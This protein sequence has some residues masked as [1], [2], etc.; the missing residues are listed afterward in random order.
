MT[1]TMR[2]PAHECGSALLLAIFLA[3]VLAATIGMLVSQSVTCHRA[4]QSYLDR[5]LAYRSAESGLQYFVHQAS[6]DTGYFSDLGIDLPVVAMGDAAFALE[7]VVETS[8]S[9]WEIIVAGSANGATFRL[10]AALGYRLIEIPRGLT[11]VGT[12]SRTTVT[13]TLSNGSIVGSFDPED[14]PFDPASPGANGHVDINGGINMSGSS[15][16]YG[17]ATAT[18]SITTSGGSAISGDIES[19]ANPIPIESIDPLI[20][21]AMT[22]SRLAN[23]NGV[24]SGIFGSQWSPVSGTQNYGDLLVTSGTYT[25]PAGTYRFRRLELTGG[26]RVTFDTSD[27][28]TTLCYVGSGDGTG[29]LND[30]ILRSGSK[31]LVDAG[32]TTNGILTIFGPNCDF[33]ISGGSVFGQEVND[34]A[35][36]GYSQMISLGGDASGDMFLVSDSEVYARLYATAHTFDLRAAAKWFGSGVIRTASLSGGPGAPAIFAADEGALGRGLFDPSSF[37]LYARWPAP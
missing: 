17:N 21:Q 20:N 35:T 19:G 26:S 7:D 34:P 29:T 37:E 4:S 1:K 31:L 25:V 28:Q 3:L 6:R 24:L 22:D 15:D 23:D 13:L 27:G 11:T 14:G 9:S 10:A 2:P 8:A 36:A 32:G 12:G 5:E 33:D 18:G 30:I 16:I